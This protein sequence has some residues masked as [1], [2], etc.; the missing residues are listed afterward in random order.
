ME[1]ELARLCGFAAPY[2]SQSIDGQQSLARARSR[3]QQVLGV[4]D[5]DDL[6]IVKCVDDDEDAG[7]EAQ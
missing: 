5:Y 4:T 1:D 2:M 7:A 6:F 3:I